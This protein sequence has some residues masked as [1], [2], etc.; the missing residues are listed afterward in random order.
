MFVN[1]LHILVCGAS[2]SVFDESCAVGA[3]R[4]LHT[5]VH[6]RVYRLFRGSRFTRPGILDERKMTAY[7]RSSTD[8]F[9]LPDRRERWVI[10]AVTGHMHRKLEPCLYNLQCACDLP[11]NQIPKQLLMTSNNLIEE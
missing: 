1:C 8:Q 3:M 5:G 10:L 7:P 4:R 2:V 9:H 6:A 11:R